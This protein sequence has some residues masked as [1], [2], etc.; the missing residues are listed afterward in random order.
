LLP[1]DLVI[2]VHTLQAPCLLPEIRRIRRVA[3]DDDAYWPL[4]LA[5]STNVAHLRQLLV[6]RQLL[7]LRRPSRQ[8]GLTAMDAATDRAL[9]AL[10]RYFAAA[11][12]DP[13]APPPPT[14]SLGAAARSALATALA[15]DA[16][17][18]APQRLAA[19]ALLQRLAR[20]DSA[21][22]VAAADPI[23]TA[24]AWT[25]AWQLRVAAAVCEHAAAAAETPADGDGAAVAVAPLVPTVLID[26][27]LLPALRRWRAQLEAADPVRTA[28]L[29]AYL[30]S[31]GRDRP[32][33][34]SAAEAWLRLDLAVLHWE[35]AVDPSSDGRAWLPH[36]LLDA[37]AALQQLS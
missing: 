2:A 14:H 18:T 11:P 30:A 21:A 31:R 28:A 16:P 15:A 22:A 10:A 34:G 6:A 35:A 1:A 32:P 5:P 26:A 23:G 29:R 17:H 9:P 25:A 13:S 8:Q 19:M 36:A 7:V 12:A 37:V 3:V 24:H 33:A 27:V 20:G 4:E